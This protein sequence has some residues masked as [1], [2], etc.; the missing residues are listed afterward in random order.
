MLVFCEF[1]VFQS[2][3]LNRNS[4]AEFKY[5]LY[6]ISKFDEEWVKLQYQNHYVNGHL[7]Y[8]KLVR[9]EANEIYS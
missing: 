6:I 9:I 7:Q 2:N 5:M 8:Q 1:H 4:N 3:D